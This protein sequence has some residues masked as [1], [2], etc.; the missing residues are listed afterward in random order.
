MVSVSPTIMKKAELRQQYLTRRA[1]LSEAYYRQKN[2]QLVEKL[3]ATYSFG[4]FRTVHCFIPS[5]RQR[6]VDTWP[7]IRRLWAIPSVQVLAP[8]CG[9]RDNTLTHHEAHP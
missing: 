8:R 5:V 4:Q 9:P 7:I 3:F 1:A 2:Q 6:E